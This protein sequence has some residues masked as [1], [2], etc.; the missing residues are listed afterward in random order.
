ML[1]TN[2][3]YAREMDRTPSDLAVSAGQIDPAPV[4]GE[5]SNT[6]HRSWGISHAELVR[7]DGGLEMRIIGTD[8]E[9]GPHDWGRTPVTRLFTDG[10]SS[11][12]ACAYT[13]TF[14][15]PHA[16][17]EIQSEVK[18][19]VSIVAALTSFTD[20]SGRSSYMSR[21]FM[22]RREL[23]AATGRA[24][25][26]TGIA[27]AEPAAARG[28]DRLAMLR[29]NIDPAILLCRWSNTNQA[30]R[31]ITEIR[32]ELR[33]GQCQVRTIAVGPQGPIDW[34]EVAGTLYSDLGITGGGRA[35]AEAMTRGR[36]T[37]HYA[38]I[39][40]TDA[41]P[42]FWAI[43]DHGFQRVHLQARINLGL[44]VVVVL[45]EFNDDSGRADYYHREFFVREA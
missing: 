36:P 14:E 25:L 9:D 40:V 37:P 16:R 3:S 26:G 19:G 12:R 22:T 5:W 10:P 29:G 39:S 43:Y 7:Q 42:A 11:S 32:C 33:D 4:L 41:G 23:R 35:A 15:L 2:A 45:T 38:D 27:P 24:P 28:E 13:A 31:G 21:E 8:L 17:T 18:Q 20:G 34:G 44:L 1:T 30:S 6:N